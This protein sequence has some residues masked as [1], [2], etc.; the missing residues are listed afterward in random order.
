MH[1]TTYMITPEQKQIDTDP[2]MEWQTYFSKNIPGVNPVAMNYKIR[3][4][5]NQPRDVHGQTAFYVFCGGR[6]IGKYGMDM[7]G[8]MQE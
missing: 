7:Q 3:H 4:N 6:K 8:Y 2:K 1:H 5:K